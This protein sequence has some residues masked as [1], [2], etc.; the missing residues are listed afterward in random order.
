MKSLRFEYI[1]LRLAEE[2]LVSLHVIQENNQLTFLK[3][4]EIFIKHELIEE[5]YNS[6]L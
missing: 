4:N 2:T 3:R 1:N 6:P 5:K